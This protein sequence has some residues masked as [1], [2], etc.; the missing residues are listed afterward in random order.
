MRE[1]VFEKEK[2][3][4]LFSLIYEENRSQREAIESLTKENQRLQLQLELNHMPHQLDTPPAIKPVNLVEQDCAI[5]VNNNQSAPL[6]NTSSHNLNIQIGNISSN[7]EAKTY[8]QGDPSN[9][10]DKDLIEGMVTVEQVMLNSE[11]AVLHRD[12]E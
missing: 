4:K 9:E 12:D 2:F 10:A 1:P 8:M 6:V 7:E 3:D 5:M 11:Q